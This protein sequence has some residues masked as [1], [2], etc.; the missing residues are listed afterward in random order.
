MPCLEHPP[1]RRHK[2]YSDRGSYVRSDNWRDRFE[3]KV[4][5]EKKPTVVIG[6]YGKLKAWSFV[7][8][9]TEPPDITEAEFSQLVEQ[10]RRDT[11]FHSSL[12]KKFTHPAY[13]TIMAGGKSVLPFILK[14][15]EN[16]PDHW[17][18]ALRF[19]VRKDIATGSESF[20][21]AR[22]AWLEWGR[23]NNYL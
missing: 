8:L 1:H 19:I 13:V 23:K 2:P 11:F 18:Y 15:L 6:S 5:S 7:V 22:E 14:E 17:F 16:N 20:D 3:E 12:S 21:D 10:W 4:A 9:H